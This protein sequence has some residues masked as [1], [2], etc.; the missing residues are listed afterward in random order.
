MI[1]KFSVFK[2]FSHKLTHGITT[3]S[4]GS[5]NSDFSHHKKNNFENNL[6]KLNTYLNTD[7][8]TDLNVKQPVYADQVHGDTIITLDKRP[9]HKP[10]GDALITN[11]SRLP[12][13]V[14]IADCQ[15]IL[16]YDPKTNTIAAVHSGWRSSAQ[17]IISKTI[18]KM[19]TEFKV[20]PAY[21]HIGISPSLGPCCA[22]F[23]DPESELP[24]NIHP[25]IQKNH[26]DFWQLSLDQCKNAGVPQNQIELAG[27][28]TKC[29]PDKYFSHRNRDT[30]RMA[31]FISLK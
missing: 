29:L 18:Q 17:N 19:Q 27:E 9:T 11:K 15:G 22:K 25:Y 7:L 8:N 13:M 4:Y 2:P 21:L 26:V 5:F 31:I 30:G 1:I 28:C 23:S 10:S 12:L 20:N 14:K 16:M 24:E 6:Q 3:K